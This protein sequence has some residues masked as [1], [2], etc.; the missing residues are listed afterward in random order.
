MSEQPPNP[1]KKSSILNQS[2][3]P[4]N[5][6]KADKRFSSQ[7]KS[8]WFPHFA[9]SKSPKKK[10]EVLCGGLTNEK[11]KEK[12]KADTHNNPLD[13]N[14]SRV[15]TW[16]PAHLRYPSIYESDS[17]YHPPPPHPQKRI[18]SKPAASPPTLHPPSKPHFRGG[19]YR[20]SQKRPVERGR[21][22]LKLRKSGLRREKAKK[23]K[24]KGERGEN[25]LKIDDQAYQ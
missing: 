1:T 2:P 7:E 18:S 8:V 13:D 6:R 15:G 11:E 14:T 23:K 16:A 3:S 5:R 17:S 24:R 19:P 9:S 4:P 10:Q 21:R 20:E 25:R 22:G 12:K